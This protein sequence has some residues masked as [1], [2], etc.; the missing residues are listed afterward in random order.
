MLFVIHGIDKPGSPLRNQL[1][2][3]HRAY[4]AAS[5]IRTIASGP[6]M[7]DWGEQIIG[8][9]IIVDCENRSAVD[10]LMADEPFNLAGLYETLTINRWHQR[11]GDIAHHEHAGK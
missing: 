10:R 4:L 9:V 5:P 3:E 7:D 6:L 1:I 11:V 8:S 2:D